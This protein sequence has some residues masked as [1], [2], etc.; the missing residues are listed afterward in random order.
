MYV[1]NV[2]LFNSCHYFINRIASANDETG[3]LLMM[4]LEQNDYNGHEVMANLTAAIY[5]MLDAKIMMLHQ[6]VLS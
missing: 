6:G 4:T 2:V 5:H 3:E 1:S